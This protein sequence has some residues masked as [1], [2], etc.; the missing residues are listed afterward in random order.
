[1]SPL[2][3]LSL[4]LKLPASDSNRM[5]SPVR[6]IAGLPESPLPNWPLCVRETSVL[7]PCSVSTRATSVLPF[8]SPGRTFDA[9]VRNATTSPESFTAGSS[10]GPSA[11]APPSPVESSVVLSC[12]GPTPTSVD[13]TFSPSTRVVCG[14]RSRTKRRGNERRK[15]SLTPLVS[16]GAR[17][18]ACDEN[19]TA[20]PEK[21]PQRPCR[22]QPPPDRANAICDESPLPG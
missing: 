1:M 3:F 10:E 16:P 17:L 7:V 13:R 22:P 20:S 4:P 9:A 18:S 11:G 12:S 14:K 19:A 15:T 6:P 5:S 8:P 2:Q 21:L